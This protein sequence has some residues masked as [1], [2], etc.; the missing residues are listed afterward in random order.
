MRGPPRP[1]VHIARVSL[2]QRYRAGGAQRARCRPA[3]RPPPRSAPR[4]AGSGIHIGI[5][6]SGSTT[7]T[8]TLASKPRSPRAAFRAR[9]C[10]E[11]ELRRG[12]GAAEL[13]QRQPSLSGGHRRPGRWGGGLL[14]QIDSQ[15]RA[16]VRPD[17]SSDDRYARG[18]P[19][20]ETLESGLPDARQLSA[21]NH[22]ATARRPVQ[23]RVD[24]AC[25]HCGPGINRARVDSA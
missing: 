25:C 8:A 19:P 10:G 3:T 2:R 18:V 21:H 24:V 4:L 17:V 14:L 5:P 15:H 16:P 1:A 11:Q 9:G 12:A 23:Q 7:R 22:R 20:H 6:A 13:R